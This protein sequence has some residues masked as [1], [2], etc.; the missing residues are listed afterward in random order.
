MDDKILQ[1]IGGAALV[2]IPLHPSVEGVRGFNQAREIARAISASTN[3]PVVPALRRARLGLPQKKLGRADRRANVA[4]AF[5]VTRR[6]ASLA[7]HPIVLVDDVI[8]TTATMRAAAAALLKANLLVSG[9]LS[10]AREA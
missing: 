1:K 7:G 10:L 3:A 2:P 5:R 6:A 9:V 8:T 4:G